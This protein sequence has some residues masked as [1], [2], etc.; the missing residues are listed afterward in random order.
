MSR[1]VSMDQVDLKPRPKDVVVQRLAWDWND[2]S[3]T[4]ERELQYIGR[5]LR[6]GCWY[7]SPM[8][9]VHSPEPT[10]GFFASV[11]K[12]QRE[13]FR[14]MSRQVGSGWRRL[15]DVTKDLYRRRI[16]FTGILVVHGQVIDP[17]AQRRLEAHVGLHP[18]SD[19]VVVRRPHAYVCLKE[20]DW[21]SLK[22]LSRIDLEQQLS[23]NPA[24]PVYVNPGIAVMGL[25]A[26]LA[27]YAEAQKRCSAWHACLARLF[28]NR[29]T[30]ALCHEADLPTLMLV[31]NGTLVVDGNIYIPGCWPNQH[32]TKGKLR[33][34]PFGLPTVTP[35]YLGLCVSP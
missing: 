7:V 30:R 26:D 20:R 17:R 22:Q 31:F 33:H 5:E 8:F 29:E 27:F 34:C 14:V 2:P 28:G 12:R 11:Q 25:K 6:K 10:R 9:R 35:D 1:I 15:M 23:A 24:D 3:E 19:L 21:E 4:V 18:E 16:G 13:W 32:P